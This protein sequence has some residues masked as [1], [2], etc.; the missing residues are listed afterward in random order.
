MKLSVFMPS[1]RT[2]LLEKWYE[3]LTKSCDRHGFE[4]IVCGPFDPPTSL[5]ELD[6]FKFVRSFASPTVCAQLAALE[7]TGEYLYH[8]TDDVIFFPYE[9]SN[10]LDIIEDEIVGMRY[11][12]GQSHSGS[13]LP[14]SYWF[15]EPSYGGMA[16]VNGE[17]G[18]CVH[19]L[20]K[21]DLFLDYGGFDCR[22]QYLNHAGHDLLF[23][24]QQSEPTTFD[25]SFNEICSADW[26]PNVTGDHSP[27]HHA[28]TNHDAPLF[29][30][31]W[32]QKNSRGKIPIINYKSQ[33][34]IW[35]QRFTGKEEKYDDLL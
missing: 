30:S 4:V 27:I 32:L 5:T 6:N 22:Y 1:I 23:R 14:R 20:M 11:R 13:E 18:I 29:Y 8:T 16:G 19:F 12:E 7:A 26:L 17:W 33:P 28:Q 15:A 9:I 24:I 2:H 31:E 21:C 10:E 3:S 34:E 25:L 35:N